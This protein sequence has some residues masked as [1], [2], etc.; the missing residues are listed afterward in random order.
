MR[1]S[2]S[3]WSPWVWIRL[4]RES[5]WQK[6]KS[7]TQLFKHLRRCPPPPPMLGTGRPP[8][9]RWRQDIV[10][11]VSAPCL[12]PYPFSSSW[13]VS[14]GCRH[15]SDQEL[16]GSCPFSHMHPNIHITYNRHS[17]MYIY[18]HW[19]AYMFPILCS[20]THSK[21]MH[22]CTH[23]HIEIQLDSQREMW[24]TLLKC[25]SSM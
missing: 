8:L 24:N 2:D 12:L 3:S 18:K 11:G 22:I 7:N 17:Y 14:L 23:I 9:A 5:L 1:R 15:I 10:G 6:R 13:L 25:L 19:Y 16:L 4:R 21:W 20:K